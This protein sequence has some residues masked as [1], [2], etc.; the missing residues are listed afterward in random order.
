MSD[1]TFLKNAVTKKWVISAPRRAK[2][3]DVANGTEPACPFCPEH[4]ED[5]EL[6]RVGGIPSDAGWQIRVVANKFPFAPIHELVINT[7][8]HHSS[9][10]N[11]TIEQIQTILQ[12]YRHRFNEH[13]H[14]GQVYIFHNHG[15]KAG[16]SIPHSHTQ[17]AVVPEKVFLDIPR[18]Q[19]VIEDVPQGLTTKHF[20]IFCPTTSVW[21]D[22][23]WVAPKVSGR[24]FGEITDDEIGDFSGILS[25]L[26]KI[27]DLRYNKDFPYNFYLY[28]GGDWYFRLIPRLKTLGGFE[29]GTNVFVNTQKPQETMEFIKE[30]FKEPN[31]E[32][33]MKEH[34]AEYHRTV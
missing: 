9:F 24:L 5:A 19:S 27:F 30:H 12:T 25:S 33:I 3:P 26:T 20:T 10:D 34:Q 21:P 18:L 15:E 16:E 11:F 13:H 29:V 32:K 14:A 7:P 4:K 2:R 31:F 6:Y 22:E 1:F 17:I 28:P 8:D 23:V